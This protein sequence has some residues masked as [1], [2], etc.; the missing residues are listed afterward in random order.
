MSAFKGL[1]TN[2]P[3]N[4]SY[5]YPSVLALNKNQNHKIYLERILV[6]NH[7]RYSFFQQYIPVFAGKSKT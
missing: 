3:S 5:T 2:S 1:Y 4:G 6:H 7:Q